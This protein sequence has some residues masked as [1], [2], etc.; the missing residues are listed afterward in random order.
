M[1]D[2]REF[3]HRMTERAEASSSVGNDLAKK[4]AL[5]IVRELVISTPVDTSKALS[6][7]QVSLN[8]R[9]AGSLP[10]YAYGN[11]GS[12]QEI[13]AVD[14]IRVAELILKN[15]KPGDVI[16]ITNN[17][18]YIRRLNEGSSTQAPA[19]FVERAE[20][21]GRKIAKSK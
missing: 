1:S 12:T 10:P 9:P 14:A 18:P 17:L 5:A 21:I 4:V 19:G 6:N 20:L 16:H 2:L 7:W 13:S 15:K 3:A 8:T 11:R